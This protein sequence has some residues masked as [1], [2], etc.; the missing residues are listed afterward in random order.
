L[1]GSVRKSGDRLR[2]TI[3]LV[4]ADNG[5][6]LWSETFDRK[7]DDIFNTQDEIAAAVVE[8]LKVSL[9][10]DTMPKIDGTK[11]TKAY[12]LY[13]RAKSSF[14]RAGK[15]ADWKKILDD[16]Q[17]TVKLDPAFAR[18]WAFL[19][20]VS[21]G[22]SGEGFLLGEPG[23]EQARRAASRALELDLR[24]PEAYAAMVK[25]QVLHDW[26]WAAARVSA[27][28]GLVLGPNNALSLEWIGE[29][30]DITG[31]LDEALVHYQKAVSNDPLNPKHYVSLSNVLLEMSRLA[32]SQAAA[33][34]AL[35]LNPE[36]LP[37]HGYIALALLL[38]GDAAG[39]LAEFER[40][41]G[42]EDDR[43]YGRALTYPA[44]GRK[45]EADDALA[46]LKRKYAASD[47]YAI[48]SIHAYRGEIDSAFAWLDKAY[49]LRDGGCS[50]VKV[51]PMLRNL[52]PD[53]RFSAFLRK[54]RLSE[55]LQARL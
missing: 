42:E 15:K 31:H 41:A 23:W 22:Q 53:P 20:N 32:E 45:A 38:N 48:A 49:D 44:L 19:A 5:Y 8:S 35:D 24:L 34:T 27:Q 47:S 16:L 55:E 10:G 29:L 43:L 21:A 52:R 54:M 17:E 4:R 37:A 40:A 46:E 36:E 39:A 6:H 12:S 50:S 3:Q 7:L 25:I 14:Y 11:S 18:A 1:E 9:L 33:R 13:L 2:I 51:D 30:E 26:D 28:Q